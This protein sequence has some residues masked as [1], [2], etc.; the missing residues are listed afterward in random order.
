MA[1][2]LS[3]KTTVGTLRDIIKE[4][5]AN[6]QSGDARLASEGRRAVLL[7]TVLL[8]LVSGHDEKAFNDI[9]LANYKKTEIDK[10]NASDADVEDDEKAGREQ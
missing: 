4:G 5:E 1:R 9:S 8:Q 6:A 3:H 7:G 2:K 10:A